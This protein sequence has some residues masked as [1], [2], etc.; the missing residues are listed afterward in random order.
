MRSLHEE[1]LNLKL[2]ERAYFHVSVPTEINEYVR[3]LT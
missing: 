3:S 2:Q 1:L